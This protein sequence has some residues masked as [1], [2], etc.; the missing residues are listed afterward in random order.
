[1]NSDID[2]EYAITKLNELLDQIDPLINKSYLVGELDKNRLN[3][4]IKAFVQ[5][6]FRD[7]DKKIKSYEDDLRLNNRRFV[8]TEES[9]EVKQKRYAKDL[10]IMRNRLIGYKDELEL[11]T[12]SRKKKTYSSQQETTKKSEPKK[13][14]PAEIRLG[15]I[16][17]IIG[18]VLSGSIAYSTISNLVSVALFGSVSVILLIF[19]LGC[20]VKPD[21]F[22]PPLLLWLEN[23]SKQ[24]SSNKGTGTEQK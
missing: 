8:H 24:N 11:L 10:E 6:A 9:D 19:G 13:Y 3:T 16:I 15:G 7:D 5:S 18:G 14:S 20:F 1:M 12:N 17:G 22:G 23:I 2:P 21:E 4:R